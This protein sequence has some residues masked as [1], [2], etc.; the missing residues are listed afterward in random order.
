MTEFVNIVGTDNLF[1]NASDPTAE[2]NEIKNYIQNNVEPE[3]KQ[4]SG[5]D[6]WTVSVYDDPEDVVYVD[7]CEGYLSC[8]SSKKRI[9]AIEDYLET[10]FFAYDTA[11]AIV[12]AD[13]WGRDALGISY[14]GGW[15]T[16]G[17][18]VAVV[19][20]GK[21]LEGSPATSYGQTAGH[22]IGHLLTAE[23]TDKAVYYNPNLAYYS[24]TIMWTFPWDGVETDCGGTNEADLVSDS[25]STCALNAIDTE[26]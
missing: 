12:V 23:H 9:I 11:S 7:K 10:N 19:D 26:L 13:H 16:S 24:A 2:L 8:D 3:I 15:D 25:F 18:K 21:D 4:G 22:E 14:T 6:D 1:A 20:L 5:S 17:E